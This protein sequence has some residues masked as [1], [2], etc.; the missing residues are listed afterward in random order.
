[1]EDAET[2][3]AK[4]LEA[5]G[6]PDRAQAAALTRSRAVAL[7]L[8]DPVSGADALDAWRQEA[9]ASSFVTWLVARGLLDPDGASRLAA[10]DA[11]AGPAL[12]ARPG[13]LLSG[14]ALEKKIGQGGMGIVWLA[15]RPDGATVVVKLLAP[16]HSRNPLWRARFACGATRCT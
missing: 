12:A 9:S 11:P 5:P 6:D 2:I 4:G 1:M 13:D 8:F 14:C 10:E 7:G 16:Q 3:S 15:R